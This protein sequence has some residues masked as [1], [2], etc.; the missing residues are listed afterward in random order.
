MVFERQV[1]SLALIEKELYQMYS[2]LSQKVEDLEAK[3]L[4]SFISIDSLKHS[5]ILVKIFEEVNT[6]KVR[7]KHCAENII[8]T[9]KLIK[10]L[11]SDVKRSELVSLEALKPI[12]KTLVSFEN[13]LLDEYNRAFHLEYTCFAEHELTKNQEKNLNIFTLIACD[14]ERHQRILSEITSL[15]GTKLSLT[16][17]NPIGKYHYPDS[18]YIPPRVKN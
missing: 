4:F 3:V 13:L 12:I 14:E 15:C 7:E 5:K 11:A 18:W 2:L 1:F 16:E 10:K 6:S 17:D 9:K 8:H